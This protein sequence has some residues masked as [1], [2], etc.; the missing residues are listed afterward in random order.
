VPQPHHDDA[1]PAQDGGAAARVAALFLM[2]LLI[3][4]LAFI[5]IHFAWTSTSWLDDPLYSLETDRGYAEFFQ[6][7]KELWIVVLLLGIWLRTRHWGFFA[8]ALLFTYLLLDDSL[9]I[10]ETLG[11]VIAANLPWDGYLGLR[12]QD[13]GELAV[14]AIA[15]GSLA[16]LIGAAYLR[17]S[18]NFRQVTHHLLMLLMLIVFFG[19]VVDMLHIAV[20][21]G[22]RVSIGLAVVEDGGE[23]VAMSLVAWYALLLNLRDGRV[24]EPLHELALAALAHGQARMQ[25]R[26]AKGRTEAPAHGKAPW[27]SPGIGRPADQ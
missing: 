20:D 23:M 14:S 4:D 22:R 3:G 2:L 24:A 7:A 27:H 26:G 21:M 15:G 10:H 9:E 16:V 1:Y 12:G 6:Y 13:Y 5:G 8:W 19:V 11:G 17:A 25:Y 18:T